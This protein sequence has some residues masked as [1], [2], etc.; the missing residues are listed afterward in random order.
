VLTTL[1][2]ALAD[3]LSYVL[4][5]SFCW[6]RLHPSRQCRGS[7]SRFHSDDIAGSNSTR[8]EHPDGGTNGTLAVFSKTR[9]MKKPFPVGKSAEL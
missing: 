2:G 5:A 1:C 7:A 8:T 9:Y 6:I 4:R 3:S